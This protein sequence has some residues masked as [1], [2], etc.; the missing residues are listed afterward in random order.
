MKIEPHEVHIWSSSLALTQDQTKQY[1]A[2][3]SKDEQT[4]ALQF[5]TMLHRERFIAARARLR[6]LLAGYLSSD[7]IQINFS[8]NHYQKPFLPDT[9]LRF[10]LSH[11]DNLVLYAFTLNHE[12]GIDVEKIKPSYSTLVAKRYFTASENN[13]LLGYEPLE[14]NIAFYRTWSR[15]EAIIKAMGKGIFQYPPFSVSTLAIN[16]TILI[17]NQAWSLMPVNTQ[18][19]FQ[20]A[21][22]SNQM[23]AQVVYQHYDRER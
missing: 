11:S 1:L 7:P 2:I 22:A 23:I 15:R 13:E 3:L 9:Q 4:R 14:A 18:T 16:E 19:G 5:H 17:E 12:I 20:A 6:Q 10:N 21:L 8:Y